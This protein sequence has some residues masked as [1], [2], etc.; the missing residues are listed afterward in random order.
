MQNI[1]MQKNEL[2]STCTSEHDKTNWMGS[3][4]E[5]TSVLN[6][7]SC[8]SDLRYFVRHGT[9]NFLNGWAGDLYLSP[10]V[11]IRGVYDSDHSNS[12]AVG[13]PAYIWTE[14]RWHL[15]IHAYNELPYIAINH[16]YIPNGEDRWQVMETVGW[17]DRC[18]RFYY[19]ILDDLIMLKSSV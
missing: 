6:K 12:R 11:Y 7:R 3:S 18:G 14:H 10:Y 2:Q 17:V 1:Y 15:C 9:T 16:C 5:A 13:N 8:A 4:T 19:M